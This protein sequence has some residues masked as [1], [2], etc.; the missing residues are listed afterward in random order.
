MSDVRIA[1]TRVVASFDNATQDITISGFG[2]PKAAFFVLVAATA[3][4][5]PLANA[6]M[7]Y[8][9]T[10]GTRQWAAAWFSEDAAARTNN[11]R[12]GMTDM[13][14]CAIAGGGGVV[15]EAAFN[16]WITDGVRITWGAFPATNYFLHVILFGGADLSVRADVVNLGTVTTT[17]TYSS[18]GFEADLL[19]CASPQ[20]DMN[21]ASDGSASGNCIGFVHNNGAGTVTQRCQATGEIDNQ[22]DG[23]PVARM[24][25]DMFAAEVNQL[26]TVAWEA[27]MSNFGTA[28]FDFIQNVN[29]A[30]DRF[31]FLALDLPSDVGS[32]VGTHNSP[33]GTGDNSSTAP[34]FTPQFVMLG[35]NACAAVDTAETDA[36]AGVWGVSMFDDTRSY[37]GSTAIE[38]A[39]ATTNTAS[40][41]DDQAIRLM[42]HAQNDDWVGT[43]SSFNADGWT[44]N[45]S[46]ADGTARKWIGFAIE[47]AVGAAAFAKLPFQHNRAIHRASRW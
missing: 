37:C 22:A 40:E 11:A 23:A 42:D 8:G 17:Q 16:A 4:D 36:D 31:G 27:S 10:D 45:F 18:M 7:G 15:A 34:G 30:S 28:G 24:F 25:E 20:R 29:S 21:D 3:D 14:A 12:R 2:T 5:T 26:G 32:W 19:I 39:A 38:D 35:L 43:F 1:V 33:T 44:L 47:E 6:Q 13:C 46:V 41:A 9:A